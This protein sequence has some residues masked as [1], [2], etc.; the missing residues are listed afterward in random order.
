MT[1]EETTQEDLE[2]YRNP[3]Q[4]TLD[5]LTSL[6]DSTHGLLNDAEYSTDVESCEVYTD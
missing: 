3:L 6:D 4:E 2:H 1:T 5:Y